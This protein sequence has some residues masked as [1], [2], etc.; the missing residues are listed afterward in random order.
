MQTSATNK[1][2]RTLLTGIRDQTLIPNPHFQ[3]RLVWSNAH[4]IAF[5]QTVLEGL[6]F[7]EIFISA[8]EVN[9]DTG[10]GT[11]LIVDGQQRMTT[12]FEYFTGSRDLRFTGSPIVEYKELDQIQKVA[13][14][15]YEVV[16]RDLGPL[17]ED[18]TRD[19]FQRINSTRY[20]LNAMEVNSSRYDG[21]L[22][23]FAE[24]LANSSFFIR[25]NIFTS[26]DGRRM[27]DVRFVLTLL[28]TIMSGYFKRDEEHET[29]LERYNDQFPDE[30]KM[31]TEMHVVFDFIESCHFDEKSRVWQK[32][33]LLTILVELHRALIVD[34]R[35][36]DPLSVGSTMTAFYEEVESVTRSES[37]QPDAA[38]YYR[39]VRSGINDR[40]SR[41][42]RGAIVRRLLLSAGEIPSK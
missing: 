38:E 25:H 2:M 14:L 10:D 21:E 6:P 37:P 41:A 8:G 31:K 12:L 42:N 7:P 11:E 40:I 30:A 29:Y 24:F 26:L 28:I 18:E 9:P 34:G 33:D 16:V 23:K 32:A 35:S 36:L 1:R 13:F 4:K 22:K 19:I 17:T 15:E 5:L 27:N 20:S 3:R 39:R